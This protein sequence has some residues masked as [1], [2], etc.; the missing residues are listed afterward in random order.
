MRKNILMFL[1][2][3]LATMTVSASNIHH[4]ADSIYKRSSQL[5]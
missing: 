4:N 1:T 5:G 2:G 3:C